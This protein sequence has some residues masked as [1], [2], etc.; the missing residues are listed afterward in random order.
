MIV[1][2]VDPGLRTTGFGVIDARVGAAPR[3][4]EAGVFRLARTDKA[5]GEASSVSARLCELYQDFN[6]LL[7]RTNPAL[8]AVEAAFAHREHPATAMVM[9]H[10]RG[11]LLLAIAQRGLELVE[12]RPAEAKKHLTGAGAA[13]K[14]QMQ[15]G[16][17]RVFKLDKPPSPADVADALAIALCACRP[18][19][20][21]MKA[22]TAITFTPVKPR[23]IRVGIVK[24]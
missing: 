5:T 19:L 12:V 17:Q 4:I 1:L 13:T 2:G 6:Q 11:V 20:G 23:L 16:I 10:A 24:G 14:E 8:V 15:R 7:D 21:T 22:R 18:S 9:G 3:L